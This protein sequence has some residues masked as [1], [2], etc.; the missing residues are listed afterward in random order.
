MANDRLASAFINESFSGFDGIWVWRPDDESSVPIGYGAHAGRISDMIQ[1][2]QGLIASAS[3]DGT[4][5]VWDPAETDS[6]TLSPLGIYGGHEQEVLRL[7]LLDNGL[8]A[9][10]SA[11]EIHVWDPSDPATTIDRLPL[12]WPGLEPAAGDDLVALADGGVGIS[13]RS[14][15]TAGVGIWNPKIASG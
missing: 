11:E 13:I 9:S 6:T 2:P 10:A 15:G 7:V 4:V 14:A 8:V 3:L 12:G 5:H 1:L